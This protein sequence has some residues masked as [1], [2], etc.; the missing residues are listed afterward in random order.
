VCH[1]LPQQKMREFLNESSIPCCVGEGCQSAVP[2]EECFRVPHPLWN[3]STISGLLTGRDPPFVRPRFR[4]TFFG[5]RGI[6]LRLSSLPAENP[7]RDLPDLDTASFVLF[8]TPQSPDL[9]LVEPSSSPCSTPLSLVV[10]PLLRSRKARDRRSL[11]ARSRIPL[12]ELSVD[13]LYPLCA[14]DNPL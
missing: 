6:G 4:S 11:K 13:T 12:T 9:S 10:F 5:P 1:L 8:V 3:G 2:G 14:L 7:N